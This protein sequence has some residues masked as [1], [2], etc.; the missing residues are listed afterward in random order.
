M[1]NSATIFA[2][3]ANTGCGPE[4]NPTFSLWASTDAGTHWAQRTLPGGRLVSSVAATGGAH[5][6]LYVFMPSVA[7]GHAVMSLDVRT[8]MFASTDDGQ[9]WKQSPS[10]G[11]PANIFSDGFMTVLGDGSVVVP[12]ITTT[13][14]GQNQLATN[15]FAQWL[16]GSVAWH[17][18]SH[19]DLHGI[20]Q[21]QT[22]PDPTTG[23]DALWL[24]APD[25]SNPQGSGTFSVETF[26]P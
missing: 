3:A 14:T 23:A 13:Q 22:L 15:T 18:I 26:L 12:F 20:T 19:L 8:S 2:I 1:P 16:P 7:S 4:N 17:P 25:S 6:T 10:Q 5:P 9:T 11:L 24:T 21:L